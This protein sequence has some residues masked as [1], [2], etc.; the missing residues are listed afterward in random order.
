MNQAWLLIPAL[1]A[2]AYV[3]M[4][5]LLWSM[6]DRLIFFPAP[7]DSETRQRLERHEVLATAA[8]GQQLAGWAIA[9]APGAK[10]PC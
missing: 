10:R 4:A 5:A 2:G 8:D 9:A 1:I 6:Q 7:L 3:A